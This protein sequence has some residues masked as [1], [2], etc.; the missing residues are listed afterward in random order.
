MADGLVPSASGEV[1]GP[2]DVVRLALAEDAFGPVVRRVDVP[3]GANILDLLEAAGVPARKARRCVVLVEGEEVPPDRWLRV[4]PKPGVRVTVGLRPAGGDGS[5]PLRVILQLVVAVA[6]AF[7]LATV[8]PIAAAFVTVLGNLAVNALV[9]P[10]RV[11][12]PDPASAPSYAVEGAGN[13]LRLFGTVPVVLGRRRLVL[14]QAARPWTEVVGDDL[15]YRLLLTGGVG[16]ATL[17]DLKVGATAID[18]VEGIEYEVRTGAAGE[19]PVTLYANAVFE[20]S[21][22]AEVTAAAGWIT[23]TTAEDADE[24]SLD[25]TWPQGLVWV[26]DQGA[27][28]VTSVTLEVQWRRVGDTAWQS[29]APT[30]G[31]AN[32]AATAAGGSRAEAAVWDS[33]RWADYLAE[34]NDP[35]LGAAPAGF[36][37]SSNETRVI[38]R[39]VKW[40]VPRA[41]YDVRV[42]R[43][44]PDV[45]PTEIGKFD[46]FVWTALRAIKA[47]PP[48][49]PAGSPLVALRIKASDTLQG[50]IEPISA[51]VTSVRPAWTGSAFGAAAAT[52][53]CADLFLS[54][55]KGPG[56]RRPVPDSRIDYQSLADWAELCRVRGWTC[57][58]VVEDGRSVAETLQAIASCGRARAVRRA[59]KIGVVV[60]V[61]RATT[62]QLYGPRNTRGFKARKRFSPAI[63]AVRVRFPNEEQDYRD[64][65]RV[66][67][68]DGFDATNATQFEQTQF[69]ALTNPARVAQETRRWLKEVELRSVTY[70]FAADPEHLAAGVGD[71][72]ELTHDVILVGA[73]QARVLALLDA[74]GAPIAPGALQAYGV[75]LDEAVTLETGKT[76]GLKVR[77]PTGAVTF[78]IATTPGTT[79]KLTF[80]FTQLTVTAPQPDE[81]VA[82]GETNQQTLEVVVLSKGRPDRDGVTA[83]VVTPNAQPALDTVGETPAPPFTTTIIRP[84]LTVLPAPRLVSASWREEGVSVS[85]DWPGTVT[86]TQGFA[87]AWR[88]TPPPGGETEWAPLPQ[89]SPA[90]R[91]FVTPPPRLA[92]SVD[93]RITPIGIEGKRGASLTI[94]DVESGDAVAPPVVTTLQGVLL[95]GAGGSVPVLRAT[96]TPPQDSRLL[97][98]SAQVRPA[99]STS[100]ADWRGLA[101]GDPFNTTHDWAGAGPPGGSVQVRLRHET[102]RGAVSAWTTP[103]TVALPAVAIPGFPDIAGIGPAINAAATTA[104]WP[105][106]T[107][108][109]RPADNA[110]VG[111]TV[112]SDVRLP[113]GTVAAPGDLLNTSVA[114]G[115]QALVNADFTQ[116]GTGVLGWDAW[117]ITDAGLTVFA[118]RNLGGFFGQ[119]LN[120]MYSL[121][122]GTPVLNAIWYGWKS[123]SGSLAD[124]LRFGLP[125]TAGDRVYAGALM[126]RYRCTAA[127]AVVLWYGPTGTFLSASVA[128]SGG[129]VDGA[130]NGVPGNFSLVGG[131]VTAPAG[132]AFAA[133]APRGVSNGSGFQPYIFWAR[134]MLA[135]VAAGQTVAPPYVGT[136]GD[137]QADVTGGNVAAA[138]A[139]QG[140]LATANPY[141]QATDPGPVPNGSLW[142]DTSTAPETLKMRVSGAWQVVANNA[143]GLTDSERTRSGTDTVAD[144]TTAGATWVTAATVTLS[145]IATGGT[146]TME[147]QL[148]GDANTTLSAGTLFNGEWRVRQGTSV[149][150]SGTFTATDTGGGLI[151]IAGDVGGRAAGNQSGTVA[152]TLQIRRASGTNE[153]NNVSATLYAQRT[154]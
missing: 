15:H 111:A 34:I 28:T 72:C 64:D 94:A 90:D 152:Y 82:F 45:T 113:G 60:D 97:A 102:R 98:L 2:G 103:A 86:E 63:H 48:S 41:R 87:V 133:F 131:F 58:L 129:L 43:L 146:V 46:A 42:R 81:L 62:G 112:G 130:V 67:Y 124:L 116:G 52:R 4:R 127:E 148:I 7:L 38:R 65:E 1:L 13:E 125:V 154:P 96:V 141:R 119:P 6:S 118:G 110:T 44:T 143:A 51:V 18:D 144:V 16:P 109:G 89:L 115:Q 80:A 75:Q 61:P 106:V 138:I 135:R 136:R 142:S 25:F 12:A 84:W 37:Y 49:V 36:S 66:V 76:Y 123:G 5:N 57:D 108:A 73:G 69:E 11:R 77:R 88:E 151:D 85:F 139:N 107:G 105:N 121:L 68:A 14:P 120:V 145:N 32:A 83:I 50:R 23:R 114:L 19:S 20:T 140:A 134:P 8:G 95:N 149:V 100:D 74:A 79:D 40:A 9:P 147:G 122:D 53:N 128:G 17:T 92:E 29:L 132:A 22:N 150:A 70:E 54:V 35:F 31:Q 78:A 24:L 71:V 33:A 104:L 126:A 3:A 10:P 137:P 55:L 59:G 101:P 56:T 153:L 27:R 47:E 91:R 117:P 30:I 99:G 21:P 26:S 93:L 39:S